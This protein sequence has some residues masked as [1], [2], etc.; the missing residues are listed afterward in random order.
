MKGNTTDPNRLD[1]VTF[2]AKACHLQ[3]RI[4]QGALARLVEPALASVDEAT[5]VLWSARGER[6]QRAGRPDEVWLHLHATAQ[7][8]RVCQRCLQTVA[9]PL[10]VD[11]RIRFVKGEA[12]AARL[13]GEGEGD[14]LALS[15]SL[16]LH[17]LIEDEL[18]LQLP[19]VPKHDECRHPAAMQDKPEG[20]DAVDSAAASPFAALASLK[21][22]DS[23]PSS[24]SR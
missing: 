6:L 20:M 17:E 21:G 3:G 2:A 8:V 4:K 18:L 1:M 11:Q 14:V 13:D 24:G 9:L 5:D 22:R 15:A 23:G 12:L 19:V 10:E 16:D 7:V